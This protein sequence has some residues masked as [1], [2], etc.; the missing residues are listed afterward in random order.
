[1]TPV[2]GARERVPLRAPLTP[3]PPRPHVA[4]LD[5]LRELGARSAALASAR[6]AL[7]ERARAAR[8]RSAEARSTSAVV[9][10]A[11][12]ALRTERGVSRA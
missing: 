4:S 7:T 6:R 8:E 9:R 11:A 2:A 5:A 1:M 12:A 10:R 3:P